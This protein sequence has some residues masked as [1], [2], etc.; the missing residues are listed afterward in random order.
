MDKYLWVCIV[1]SLV[2]VT[3]RKEET[4]C[5]SDLIP[6]SRCPQIS[7]S[8]KSFNGTAHLL[9]LTLILE[10]LLLF[11]CKWS[12]TTSRSSFASRMDWLGKE[13]ISACCAY[14]WQTLEL[15]ACT[16]MGCLCTSQ[17]FRNKSYHNVYSLAPLWE[18]KDVEAFYKETSTA[19]KAMR[20]NIKGRV[21]GGKVHSQFRGH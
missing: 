9:P 20:Q 19:R 3:S 12:I 8:G 6:F 17:L 10:N 1:R 13:Q 7:F 2:L 21:A 15:F 11:H 18:R 4:K 16:R 14:W 5:R